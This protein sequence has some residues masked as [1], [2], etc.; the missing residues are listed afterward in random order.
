MFKKN[1]QSK[2]SKRIK[3]N[4]VYRLPIFWTEYQI[5]LAVYDVYFPVKG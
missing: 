4:L 5:Q 1:D 3:V 2:N